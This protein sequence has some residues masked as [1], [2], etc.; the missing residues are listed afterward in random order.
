M[1]RLSR[2]ESEWKGTGTWQM[3]TEYMQHDENEGTEDCP[4]RKLRRTKMTDLKIG[5]RVCKQ[6]S[7]VWGWALTDVFAALEDAP[8]VPEAAILNFM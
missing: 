5:P 2:R 6:E 1:Q 3:D 4:Y 7:S 8:A